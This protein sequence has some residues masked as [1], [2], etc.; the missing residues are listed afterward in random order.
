MNCRELKNRIVYLLIVFLSTAVFSYNLFASHSMGADLT[1]VCLGNNKYEFTL[2]FYRDCGGVAA[3]TSATINCVALSCN[4]NYSVVLSKVPGTGQ[5]VTPIC[6]NVA[7]TCSGGNYP[8]VQEYVYTGITTLPVQCVDWEFSFSL[9]CRNAA[10]TTIQNPGNENIYIKATLDNLNFP[11]NNSPTFSNKPVPWICVGQKICYNNGAVEKDGDQLVFSIITPYTGPTTNVTYIPPFTATQPLSTTQGVSFNQATGDICMNPTALLVTV[12]AIEVKEYRNGMLV[13]SVMRD[14]QMRTVT[15]SN[16]LP[17]VTGVN[18]SSATYAASVCAGNTLSFFINSYDADP[19]QNVTMSWNN[20][21]PGAN[22]SVS[23]GP[24]PTGYFTWTPSANAISSNPYCFTVTVRDDNCPYNGVQ[25]FSFCIT[26]TGLS[27]T[28]THTNTNCGASN[29]TAAVA[30]T[31]GTQPYSYSWIP[32]GGNGSAANGL[33]AGTYTVI[34]TDATG[35]S[36]TDTI[37]ISNAT[38]NAHLTVSSVN[39]T[40]NNT[41]NGSATVNVNGGQQPYTYLWSNGATTPTATGLA[42]GTYSVLL[43]TAAACSSAAFVT[44]TQPLPMLLHASSSSATCNGMNNGTAAVYV[45]GGTSPYTY[46]WCNGSTTSSVSSLPAG[47]CSATITDANACSLQYQVTITQPLPMQLS[48]T[49]VNPV[50]CFG[51]N[52]G[53]ASVVVSGGTTPYQYNWS[54]SPIQTTQ[55][56]VNLFSGIYWV[57][58]SDSNQCKDSVVVLVTQPIPLQIQTVSNSVTCANQYNG[59]IQANVSGGNAPYSF[60]WSTAPVQTTASATGLAAGSYTLTVTDSKGCTMSVTDSVFQPITL[61]TLVSTVSNIT[62][63]GLNNGVATVIPSGGTVPYSYSWSTIPLQLNATATGLAP[64]IYTV[65]VTDAKGCTAF[66]TATISQ[67]APITVQLQGA[68]VVCPGTAVQLSALAS[69]GSGNYVYQWNNNAGTGSTITVNPQTTTTYA[70]IVRDN[71]GCNSQPATAT[72]TVY[73]ISPANIIISNPS[74]ICASAPVTLTASIVGLTGPVQ[75][76]WNNNLGFSSSITVNP[77]LTTT[78]TVYVTNLCGQTASN[79]VTVTV[80]A[81]PI[82]HLSPQSAVNCEKVELTFFDSSLINAGILY[83]W[84]F[85]DGS[86]ASAVIPSHTYTQS[87]IYTVTVTV[88]GSQG[89]TSIAS[90]IVNVNVKPSPVAAFSASPGTATLMNPVISFNNLSQ[91]AVKYLWDFGDGNTSTVFSPDHRYSQKGMYTVMLI[92][93]AASG[94]TDTAY[95]Q[96]EIEPEF[97]FYIPNAFSPNGDGLNDYFTGTGMEIIL[98]QMQI[99]DRWGMLIFETENMQTGWD[100]TVNGGSSVAQEDVYIYKIKVKDFKNKV[101][102]YIGHVTLIK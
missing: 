71:N 50:S 74:A 77:V 19:T 57:V 35:C 34:V 65:I 72:V 7:S 49:V 46:S 94:C 31:G 81:S 88:T 29:G 55:Q 36:A 58:V 24:R 25:I 78:Y 28:T 17:G 43:L 61:S 3:P 98:F 101:H 14:I 21:I 90:A 70:V 59:S 73:T 18:G 42:A 69:G 52:N 6:P 10:I 80:M 76:S 79:T 20:G 8:G 33:Q 62:C 53:S 30:V 32:T 47:V 84:N 97:S 60:I 41:A 44:I 37:T 96:V 67:P 51:G 16:A 4:V 95:Q 1:Y 2:K 22:F 75:Y 56:A 23:S 26:V 12:M 100:G 48:G 63:F 54:T 11:C 45:A 99:F 66:A 38:S 9:C 89:C 68:T 102:E 40:C 92:S 15:C 5:E 83:S 64:G 93:Y 13:G 39:A 27:T 87:G 82:I 85:G 86:T 91:R